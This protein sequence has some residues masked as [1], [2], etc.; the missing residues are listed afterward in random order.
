MAK[1]DLTQL[2]KENNA[3][4]NNS[5]FDL[6]HHGD[7]V[8][9]YTKDDRIHVAVKIQTGLDEFRSTLLTFETQT[10]MERLF[11]AIMKGL[12]R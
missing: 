11:P 3:K 8:I 12:P 1:W 2:H 9:C 7:E 10:Q 4:G 5:P 6:S